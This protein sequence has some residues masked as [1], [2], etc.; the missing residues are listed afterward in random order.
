MVLPLVM[1]F[2]LGYVAAALYSA[3]FAVRGVS[4]MDRPPPRPH[5][6]DPPA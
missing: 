3:W 1:V 4:D 5:D 2:P 6:D